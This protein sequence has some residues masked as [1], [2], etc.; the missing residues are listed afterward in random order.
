MGW[1]DDLYAGKHDYSVLFIILV[2]GLV[3]LLGGV[4]CLLFWWAA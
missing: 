3:L 2:I 4:A 1:M